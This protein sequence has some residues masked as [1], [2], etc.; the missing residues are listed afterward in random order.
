MNPERRGEVRILFGDPGQ[1][2]RRL[3]RQALIAAGYAH[4]RE[5]D[6]LAGFADLLAVAQPDLVFM[7]TGMPGGDAATLISDLRHSRLGVNP[8]LPVVL[9]TWDTAQSMVR[10][11]IDAGADDLLVK[12]LSTRMPVSYTHLT[13]P[14]N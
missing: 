11:F 5:F 1:G 8:F 14:T 12:P 2:T 10:K 7:D 13:L 4:L 6:S 9:T 3:Y